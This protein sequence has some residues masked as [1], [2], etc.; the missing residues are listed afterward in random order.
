MM[1]RLLSPDPPGLLIIIFPLT[2]NVRVWAVQPSVSEVTI[3]DDPD[4]STNRA[5]HLAKPMVRVLIE[6]EGVMRGLSGGKC[7]RILLPFYGNMGKVHRSRSSLVNPGKGGEAVVIRLS[8]KLGRHSLAIVIVSMD[9]QEYTGGSLRVLLI[10]KL[11]S[12]GSLKLGI[13][14]HKNICHVLIIALQESPVLVT[15][16]D[17]TIRVGSVRAPDRDTWAMCLHGPNDDCVLGRR[18]YGW[19]HGGEVV[20]GPGI[21]FQW[22]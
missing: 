6:K 11:G 2:T 15:R 19:P 9:Q 8:R 5:R 13:D 14:L 7:C 18:D 21:M 20:A 22:A 10:D 16:M 12:D 1:A 4:C 17:G 3:D